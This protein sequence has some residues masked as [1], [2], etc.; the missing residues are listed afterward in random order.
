MSDQGLIK[1]RFVC[2]DAHTAYAG[3]IVA[4]CD[5][6]GH[7]GTGGAAGV[8]LQAVDSTNASVMI[9][10]LESLGS[11]VSKLDV[12]IRIV[13]EAAKV[14]AGD[15]FL[16]DDSFNSICRYIRISISSG[17]SRRRSTK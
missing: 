10:I 3:T 9:P 8:V 6:V 7:I 16:M 12:F 5:A 4:G 14:C 13:D 1:I 15:L 11:V 2:E 17:K